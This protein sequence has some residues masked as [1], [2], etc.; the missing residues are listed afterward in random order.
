[1]LLQ[2]SRFSPFAPLH[3]VPPIPSSN[4]HLSSCPWVVHISSLAAPFPI[5]F[6]IA[7]CLFHT[8]QFVLLNPCAFFPILPL[9]FP[10]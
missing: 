5:L 3:P 8:Y 9:P 10:N 4:T 6:L 2:L 1:M 7:T